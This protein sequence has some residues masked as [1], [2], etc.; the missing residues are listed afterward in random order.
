MFNESLSSD[1]ILKKAVIA[2]GYGSNLEIT[3]SLT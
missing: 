2:K 1:E 3:F